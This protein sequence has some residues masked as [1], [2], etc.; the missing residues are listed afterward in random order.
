M[1]VMRGGI[2]RNKFGLLHE[3]LFSKAIAGSK[4]LVETYHNVVVRVHFYRG[5]FPIWSIFLYLMS[6]F[7][8]PFFSRHFSVCRPGLCL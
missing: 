3:D 4:V 5:I 1:F 8:L 2:G 7:C 6:V